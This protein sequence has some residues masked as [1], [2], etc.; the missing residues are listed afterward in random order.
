MIRG[1]AANGEIRVFAATTKHT[2]EEARQRHNL[3]PVAC[4]ALGRLLT[5]G[6]MMGAMMKN[7]Q[8][9]LTVKVQGDGPLGAITVTADASGRVKGY[10]HHPQAMVPAKNGKL[11]VAGGIGIG[12]LSVIKDLGLKEPYLG[13]TILA[14]SEIAEDLTYY[15]ANSEQVPSSVG[16]GVLMN[17]NNTVNC[18]GG[19]IIQMMPFASEE[20]ISRLEENLQHITSIT[21]YLEKGYAPTELIQEVLGDL[22]VEIQDEI[23]IRFYCNCSKERVASAVASIGV[24]DLEEIIEAEEDI[25]VKCHFCNT[26]YNYSVEDLKQVLQEGKQGE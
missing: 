23:P 16:L 9:I 15:F 22:E 14:T 25:E 11:D 7:E 13:Q 3:S 19:F 4:A 10:V 26:A 2:V 20:T 21:S 17:K 8:D 12:V 1:L 24:K 18:A 6:A 5:G